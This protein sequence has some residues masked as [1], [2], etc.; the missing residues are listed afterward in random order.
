MKAYE[1]MDVYV[2]VVLTSALDGSEWSASLF[3]R[4]IPGKFDSLDGTQSQSGR[5]GEDNS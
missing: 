2:H 3:G 4:F 1:G 5:R